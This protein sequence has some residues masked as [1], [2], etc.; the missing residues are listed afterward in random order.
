MS[1]EGV[2]GEKTEQATP[3]RKQEAREKGQV[4]KS[5][6]LV[7]ALMMLVMF[8]S[9][10]F[11]GPSLWDQLGGLLTGILSGET[12]PLFE[13]TKESASQILS[14]GLINIALFSL[15]VLVIAFAAALVGNMVQVGFLFSTKAL[16]PK[17]NRLNPMEGIKR[18]FSMRTLYELAKTLLKTVLIVW[19]AYGCYMDAMETF[20]AMATV[21]VSAA[22]KELWNSIVNAGI[23]IG[24]VLL[25]LSAVDYLYQWW[26]HEKDLRMTKY[27]VKL[28]YK[29]LEGDP[30]IKGRIK[31]KQRQMAMM[32]TMQAVP[33]A[34]VVITNPTHFAV[35]LKYDEKEAPAPVVLAK[36]QDLLAQRMKKI[37]AE[38]NV[39][40][41]ENK[42]VARALYAACDVGSQIPESLFQAVA[43]ILA[44]VYKIKKQQGK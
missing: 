33:E 35:A 5:M 41:V 11:L 43:E 9:L 2:G 39:E 6:E 18:M 19:V 30:Q 27:E 40:I 17:F 14:D 3:K 7:T 37:A 34:D 32:R 22:V 24:F 36:G 25:L 28:E 1:N 44:Q 4:L 12:Y 29:Q 15:P 8:A 13:L 21:A 26:R 10:S 42:L 23:T 31:Q 16:A 20:A 38:N